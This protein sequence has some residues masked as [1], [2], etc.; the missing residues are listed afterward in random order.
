M[1]EELRLVC[2]RTAVAVAVVKRFLLCSLPRWLRA[3]IPSLSALLLHFAVS[4]VSVSVI[5]LSCR[6]LP[7]RPA[8]PTPQ[9]S[10]RHRHAGLHCRGAVADVVRLQEAYC[11]DG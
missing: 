9:G 8:R 7:G 10:S 6:S 2:K 1:G 4:P 3:S 5:R 11:H